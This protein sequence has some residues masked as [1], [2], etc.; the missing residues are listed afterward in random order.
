VKKSLILISLLLFSYNFT[1]GSVPQV[2]NFQGRLTDNNGTPRNGTAGLTFKL[3]GTETGGI[4][5]W[6][7]TQPVVTVTN[8]AFSV[9]LGTITP[10]GTSNFENTDTVWL[11][12]TVGSDVLSPRIQMVSSAYAYVSNKSYG[13][14][15]ATI[16]TANIVNNTIVRDDIANDIGNSGLITN[17]NADLFDNKHYDSF[18]TTGTTVLNTAAVTS[19][20]S[21]TGTGITGT[22]PMFQ[23]GDTALTVLANGNTGIGTTSPAQ[24]LSVA[25][26]IEVTGTVDGVDVSSQK[27]VFYVGAT[28]GSGNA[29]VTPANVGL[30]TITGFAVFCSHD[31]GYN[32]KVN[33][34]L[35]GANIIV[36]SWNTSNTAAGPIA[37]S[38]LAFG[39]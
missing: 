2:I 5:S 16:T 26:N 8:G 14:I 18:L 30:T 31:L 33:A 12:I 11:E 36:K 24:K 34:D 7:E 29:T 28:D 22:N 9:L 17:L 25:G 13:V 37:F 10:L 1:F 4:A 39:Q 23:T 15:G 21:I 3:Y 38:I 35:S 19:S 32:F 27:M 6:T 20:M